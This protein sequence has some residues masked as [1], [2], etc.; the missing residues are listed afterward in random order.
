MYW[1]FTADYSLLDLQQQP[2]TRFW[3]T[4]HFTD[5]TPPNAD[6]LTTTSSQPKVMFTAF[7]A[8]RGYTLHIANL[9][10]ARQ[11]LIE[12]APD[13][14]WRGVRT[15]QQEF[16]AESPVDPPS[17]GVLALLLPERCLVTLTMTPASMP[18]API[19]I[20]VLGDR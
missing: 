20:S 4:R 8:E 16:F 12:G 2:T 19:L 7:H 10:A 15:G 17:N 18:A 14:D 11:V 5:L 6:A 13:G 3:L 9:G 1:E